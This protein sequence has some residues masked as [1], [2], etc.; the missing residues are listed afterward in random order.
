MWLADPRDIS[1]TARP[2][3]VLRSL[4]AGVAELVDARDLGSRDA[5]RGGSNPSARTTPGNTAGLNL[6]LV[7]EHPGAPFSHGMK[8]RLW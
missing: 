1:R 3:A 7:S 8:R 2:T 4:R 5:S 6:T